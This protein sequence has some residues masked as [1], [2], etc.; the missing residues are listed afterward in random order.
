MHKLEKLR[1]LN[2][3]PTQQA[4]SLAQAIEDAGGLSINLPLLEIKPTETTWKKNLDNLNNLGNIHAAIF[5]SPNAVHTFFTSISP[6][7][8]PQ[9]TPILAIG[10]GTAE[11]LIQHS[12]PAPTCPKQ[13][14]SEHLLQLD[15]LHTTQIKNK[16]ILLIKG[17]GGRT[18]INT[19]LTARGA[20]VSILEVYQRTLPHHNKK[21]LQTLWHEDAVEIILITSET[22]LTHLF[23]LFEP[24]GEQA[25]A[26]LCSKPYMVISDR[27]RKA[28]F[29]R[30]IQTVIVSSYEHIIHQ[31]LSYS[32][33]S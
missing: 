25:H 8:W 19:V 11:A 22:A 10:K 14:N 13:P 28:A 1:V 31:L 30:G 23:K 5:T 17:Q 24:F 4:S 9:N 2:T 16:K 27:L 12:L 33:S 20:D 7:N 6:Q 21:R 26:W 32:A 3:R 29:E 15:A 18:L